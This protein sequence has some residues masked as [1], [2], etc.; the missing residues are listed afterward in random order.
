MSMPTFE[1]RSHLLLL[2]K[3]N[4]LRNEAID[5]AKSN[6]QPNGKNRSIGGEQLKS[7]LKSGEIPN[8]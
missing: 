6:S 3:E 1:R 8:G 5:D 7:K 4:T 2:I